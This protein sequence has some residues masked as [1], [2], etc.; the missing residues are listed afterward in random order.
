MG[1]NMGKKWMRGMCAILAVLTLMLTAGCA[2]NTGNEAPAGTNATVGAGQGTTGQVEIDE[3][4][5]RPNTIRVGMKA[6]LASLNPWAH[7][8]VRGAVSYAIYESLGRRE[9]VG[10]EMKGII[11]KD[12][13]T[14]DYQTYNIEIYDYVYDSAGNHITADD[15][16][17][18]FEQYLTYGTI[19]LAVEYMKAVDTYKL[20]LKL[21]TKTLGLLE[22]CFYNVPIVSKKAFEESPDG[23]A[24]A[25]ITTSHYI[26]TDY[27][28]GSHVTLTKN[29]NYWQTDESLYGPACAASFD[30]ITYVSIQEAAQQTIALETGAIDAFV[31]ASFDEIAKFDKNKNG[32]YADEFDIEWVPYNASNLIFFSGDPASNVSDDLNL[33]LAIAHAIDREA[34]IQAVT[35]GYAFPVEACASPF[36]I[37]YPTADQGNYLVYDLDLAKEFL[38]KSNYDGTAIRVLCETGRNLRAAQMIA[39]MLEAIGIKT[40][41]M[42]FDTAMFQ[43]YDKDPSAWDI[44]VSNTGGDYS[45]TMWTN[46]LSFNNYDGEQTFYH[47]KDKE[48]SDAVELAGSPEGFNMDNINAA[49]RIITD[50][51][52]IMCLYNYKKPTIY[53]SE[54]AFTDIPNGST[55]Y[56]FLWAGK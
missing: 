55:A 41:I 49:E 42:S 22:R 39:G 29:E 10:G 6:T 3:S 5:G 53:R 19:P 9:K 31:D 15:V 20:E 17:Y 43:T 14:D 50:N 27:T 48:L 11:A 26:V 51:V 25:P 28:A 2:A 13:N 46:Y 18:C 33:R 35:G 34:L 16:A 44:S 54:Y 1:K 38:A 36:S 12:W 37:S 23:M 8:N 56:A 52:Y 40:E 47:W 30:E 4:T 45:T 24:T 21:K 32:Q 7:V